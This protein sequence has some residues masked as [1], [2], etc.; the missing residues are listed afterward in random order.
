MYHHFDVMIRD[1]NYRFPP[2][3]LWMVPAWDYFRRH[4]FLDPLDLDHGPFRS[5]FLRLLLFIAAGLC[6][7]YGGKILTLMGG[8]PSGAKRGVWFCNADK[9]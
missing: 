6:T 1:T 2:I 9:H 5:F 8:I 4:V 3:L 7:M